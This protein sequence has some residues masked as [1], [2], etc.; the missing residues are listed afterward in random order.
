MHRMTGLAIILTA[1]IIILVIQL[2][3]TYY[4][5]NERKKRKQRGEILD[6]E[7]S[8]RVNE[9]AGYQTYKI[10]W[11]MWLL[12]FIVDSSG[13][14]PGDEGIEMNWFLWSG[15]MIMWAIFTFFQLRYR[16]QPESD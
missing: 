13:I 2:G 10:T 16:Q 9:K 12:I 15:V 14:L 5:L 1:A 6:D 8:T 11:V 3:V 4:V 7:L